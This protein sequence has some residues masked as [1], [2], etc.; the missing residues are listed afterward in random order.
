MKQ[1]TKEY[2]VFTF[3]E[4]SE[5][6]QAKVL[7][8]FRQEE[9]ETLHGLNDYL[10]D[11]LFELLEN[12]NIAYE[13]NPKLYYSLSYCQGDGVM[14]EGTFQWEGFTFV[15]KH[16]GHYNHENSKTI[17]AMNEEGED[18]ETKLEEFNEVYVSICKQL[19]KLGY[20]YIEDVT[21]DESV[22]DMILV[23]EYEFLKDGTVF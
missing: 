11:C 7:E 8:R 1:V 22:K 20:D 14:F 23:N 5:E 2:E 19:E 18:D 16:S 12:D 15:V 4:L 10:E 13:E 3:E 9:Y 21:S 6:V 17:D